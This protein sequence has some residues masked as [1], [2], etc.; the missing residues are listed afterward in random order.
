[1]REMLSDGFG[2][3]DR[4]RSGR[5]STPGWVTWSIISFVITTISIPTQAVIYD[6]FVPIAFVLGILQGGSVLLAALRPWWGAIAQFAAVAGFVAAA[7]PAGGPW[8]MPVLGMIALGG[9]LVALGLHGYWGVGAV[10]LLAT[11][12]VLIFSAL[13]AA[14]F[15]TLAD[16]AVAN[17]IVTASTTALGLFAAAVVAQLLDARVEVR[18]AREQTEIERAHVLWQ[19]ER[20]RIAREMHD[21]V[22]HSMSIVHMRATSARYRLEALDADAVAEFDGIAEQARAALREMRGLLGVLREGDAVLDAPQPGLADL[23]A[24][25]AA[26]RDAGVAITASLE[27]DAAET[28][29]PPSLQLALYRVAQESLS[30]VVRHARGA[31]VFVGLERVGPELWLTVENGAPRDGEAEAGAASDQGGHGIRGMMERMTSV[32]GSLEHG[33]VP[34]GGYRVVARAP[35]PLPPPGGAVDA[36]APDASHLATGAEGTA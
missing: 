1:M 4:A 8:P 29:P 22:A 17:L 21:V 19:Q 36:V 11:L 2:A 7:D 5:L 6:V 24:L 25:L 13:L 35:H 34:G 15:G 10:T 14:A 26:T 33:V 3:G 9:V 32:G 30:N 23:P 31:E 28:A 16:E 27:L 18:E 12:V 20:A